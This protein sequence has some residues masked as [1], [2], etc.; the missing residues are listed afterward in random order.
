[1]TTAVPIL[2]AGQVVA[3][4]LLICLP[5]FITLL[6]LPADTPS[7]RLSGALVSALAMLLSAGVWAWDALLHP[8]INHGLSASIID[9]PIFVI[10]VLLRGYPI[11]RLKA[12][13]PWQKVKGLVVA[14]WGITIVATGILS[15]SLISVAL[16][17]DA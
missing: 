13:L 11:L 16:H 9:T 6:R 7:R 4:W 8:E 15:A 5:A 2:T 3:T 17:V 12:D 14:S 10:L 1:V